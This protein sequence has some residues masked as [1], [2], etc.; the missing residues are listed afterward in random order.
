MIE[1]DNFRGIK[2][3]QV[4]PKFRLKILELKDDSS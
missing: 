3:R 1:P 2:L 4:K